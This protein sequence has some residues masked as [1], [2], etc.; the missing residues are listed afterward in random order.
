M[1]DKEMD[2][3]GD[4]DIVERLSG[5]TDE[6]ALQRADAL[7]RGLEDYDLD[8]DDI[9]VSDLMLLQ[10]AQLVIHDKIEALQ[11]FRISQ[12]HYRKQ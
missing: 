3:F 4:D 1:S 11:R 10:Q 5:L 8:D 2:D 7:R 12:Q 6:D 9:A